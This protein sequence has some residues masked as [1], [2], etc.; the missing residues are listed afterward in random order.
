MALADLLS[1]KLVIVT[2]KG[3]V[4]KT[5]VTAAIARALAAAGRRVLVCEIVPTSETPSQVTHALGGPAPGEE[6]VRVEP[7][8]DVVLLTPTMGH[9]R[10]LQDTLPLKVLADA[11]MR[12]Q[13]LKR[14]LIAAPGFSDMGV[15]YRAVDF[16]RKPLWDTMVLDSPATG[17][18]LALAQIPEFLARVIL[19][20]PIAR[21]AREGVATLTDPAITT[22][23][24]VTLPETLPVTEALELA[25]GLE[26][27]RLPVTGVIVNR[28]PKDPFS[29]DERAA[30][31]KLVAH[32]SSVLGGRELSRIER[33]AA[34]LQL[35]RERGGRQLFELEELEI[36]GPELSRELAVRL[37]SALPP[38]A[39]R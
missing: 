24:V 27:H 23:V 3:G 12:S 17:H 39:L 4:G 21:V 14:F 38:S 29:A 8:I 9:R 10:F 37:S 7:N 19:K 11:A 18:A 22:A 1:R 16:M 25:K 20:G 15:L 31:K 13:G 30:V 28:V 2:G 36:R 33:S 6:P 32:G 5:T 35:L 34:A 26:K